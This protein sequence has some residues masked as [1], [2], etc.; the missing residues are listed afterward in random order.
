LN[1]ALVSKI[2]TLEQ[3]RKV[4]E[5]AK[6][7]YTEDEI[8]I[9]ARN[10][11]ITKFPEIKI[12]IEAYNKEG[13]PLEELSADNLYVYED[14]K[15]KK[16]LRV[17]KIPAAEVVPV[18]FVFVL[19]ITGSMQNKIDMLKANIVKFTEVLNLRGIDYRL[20]LVLFSDDLEMVYQPITDVTKFQQWLTEVKTK[21]GGDEPEN[22]L[23]ALEAAA[24]IKYRDFADKVTVLIT[25]ASYHQK[26][27]P[28]NGVTNQTTE[29]I[30]DLFM[31]K[32][33]RIFP[34]VPPK[35]KQYASM[36]RSTRGSAYDIESDF[37]FI[38]NNF[39]TQLTNL[40][41][42][43][44]RSDQDAIPDEIEIALYDE[45]TQK[46][47]KRKIPIVE[48]GRKLIIENLL[49]E[50]NDASLPNNVPELDIMAKFMR[51]KQ[52][53]AIVVEGH[54]DSVGPDAVNDY[55]SK[56]RAESVKQYIVDRGVAENRIKTI[57]QGERRPIASNLTQFGRKLNRR[58]EIIIISK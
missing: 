22:A 30:V 32:N 42:M 26:N 27:V 3:K 18:D 25:D 13:E 46:L 2:D 38:L 35:F 47:V 50:T 58:T 12:I 41:A 10:V 6:L 54:T 29:S 33:I 52:N 20:G 28:G 40:F 45:K 8:E 43:Y 21:G 14:G 4:L 49:Y 11:D 16:V 23:E 39:S 56:K 1:A 48:L 36:A 34:I 51:D 57:G 53:I 9:T 31:T 5:G 15:Q 24:K 44:Y 37:S 7:S 19:D 17:E 55:L